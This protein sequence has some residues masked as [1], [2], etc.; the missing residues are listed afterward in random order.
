LFPNA[1]VA[2]RSTEADIVG[3][4]LNKLTR[5]VQVPTPEVIGPAKEPGR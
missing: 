5:R 2:Q 4:V 3:Q 1:I